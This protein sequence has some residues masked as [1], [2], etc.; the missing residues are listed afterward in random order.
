MSAFGTAAA[1]FGCEGLR[2]TASE[3][4]FFAD[5]DPMG[6]IVFARNVENPDQLRALCDDFRNAVG[7]EAPILVDQEGG[8]VQR[9]RAPHWR[10][11]LPPLDQVAAC[12]DIANAAAVM[13]LRSRIMA[14]E[15]RAVGIDANCAPVA[16][17]ASDLTHPFLRNRCYGRTAADVTQIARAVMEGHL[18]GG[19]LPVVK[20]MPGHGRS[21]N[22]THH[23]LP[24]VTTDRDTL[25]AQD[26]AP[27]TALRDAPMAM[28]AHIVFSACDA[29]RPATQSPAMIGVIRQDIGFDG[30]LMTDDLNMQ[31]LEGSLA[32]RTARS[33]A[34]GCDIALH[35]KGDMAEMV[36]VAG[37][38]GTMGPATLAR[39]KAALDRRILPEF[40]DMGQ[41]EAEFLRLTQG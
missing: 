8:R 4:A 31:A 33:M 32:Q 16:D 7:R 37:A 22:D 40:T 27:F 19:V 28:T 41:L 36:E 35:C 13:A 10:E 39:V 6:F 18:A 17:I 15:L 23:D 2:L 24:T 14:A 11:W 5:I 25:M 38:A 1:I 26:F 21:Q 3:R 9:L 30:L 29:T 34:A 12:K 20:H